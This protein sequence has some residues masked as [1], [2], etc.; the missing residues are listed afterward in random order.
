MGAKDGRD[1]FSGGKAGESDDHLDL[2]DLMEEMQ[3]TINLADKDNLK[4]S[5]MNHFKLQT[6]DVVQIF[7][8]T[9]RQACH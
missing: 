8:F 4:L 2:D 3:D 1:P 9:G 7:K 6:K 5:S